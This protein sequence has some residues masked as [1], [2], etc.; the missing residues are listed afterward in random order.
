MLN[1]NNETIPASG[2]DHPDWHRGRVEYSLWMI[3][4]GS[5]EIESRVHAAREYLSGLLLSSYHRQP[6]ITLFVCGFLE[7]TQ[8]FDDD[9]TMLQ[10]QRQA[11]ALSESGIGPFSLEIGGLNSFSSAP[12]L[13]VHDPKGQLD[14]LRTVLSGTRQEIASDRFTPHITVGLYSNVFPGR[15]VLYRMA[16]FPAIPSRLDVEQITFATYRAQENAGALSYRHD[17]RLRSR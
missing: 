11:H 5:N 3:R 1:L 12:F 7:K 6:H 17:I 4:I 8:R 16:D 13:E 14:R 10:F 2:Q 9:Y 15:M